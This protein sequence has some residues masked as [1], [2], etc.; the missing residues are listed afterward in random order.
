MSIMG[1]M[2]MDEGKQPMHQLLQRQ[3][4]ELCTADVFAKAAAAERWAKTV[5]AMVVANDS[6]SRQIALL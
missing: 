2:S 6:L 5:T 3:L 4:A 1:E